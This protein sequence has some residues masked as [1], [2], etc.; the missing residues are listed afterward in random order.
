M[1]FGPVT[2]ANV[3]AQWVVHVAASLDVAAELAAAWDAMSDPAA[4]REQG[5]ALSEH[6]GRVCHFYALLR[7][8]LDDAEQDGAALTR[9]ARER[10]ARLAEHP[11]R[12]EWGLGGRR[13]RWT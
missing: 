2:R 7:A 6:H 5:A 3:R 11:L 13:E 4:A 10:V 9:A 8:G 1:K 12:T